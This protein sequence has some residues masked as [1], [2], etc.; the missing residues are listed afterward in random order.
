MVY[1]PDGTR[2]HSKVTKTL[3]Q[4]Q[5]FTCVVYVTRPGRDEVIRIRVTLLKRPWS[6]DRLTVL[7]ED[8]RRVRTHVSGQMTERV[9]TTLRLRRQPSGLIQVDKGKRLCHR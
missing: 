8:H 6:L 4:S 3:S 5:S 7:T 1:V 2:S 9:R